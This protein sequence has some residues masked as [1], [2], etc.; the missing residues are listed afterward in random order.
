MNSPYPPLPQ[1]KPRDPNSHKGDFGKVL[2]IGGSRGMAGSISLSASA[3]VRS[4]AGLVTV[5]VPD[6]CLETVASFDRCYMTIGLPD[7][8]KGFYELAASRII[9]HAQSA[10][11]LG[12]GPGMRT[13][14]GSRRI[15]SA[16]LSEI[17]DKPIVLDADGLNC[18]SKLPDWRTLIKENMILTPHPGEWQRLLPIH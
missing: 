1:L 14:I 3:S 2:L 16:L 4:G 10:T 13:G 9:K 7:D 17:D 6:R 12:C 15:V 11:V 18:L 8:A 5:A